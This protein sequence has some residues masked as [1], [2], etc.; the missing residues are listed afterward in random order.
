MKKIA[1]CLSM[2]LVLS[3]ACADAALIEKMNSNK[4]LTKFSRGLTNIA[5]SPGEF[6]TQ[7]PK[8][9]DQSP[10]YV[11]GSI[12]AVGRGVGYTLLRL[13]AGIYDVATFPFPGATNYDPI[14]KPETVADKVLDTTIS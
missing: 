2:M 7:I 8:A 11:T 4:A 6:V 13:G 14:M 10:D 5:T 12:M 9:M 3:T 1:L